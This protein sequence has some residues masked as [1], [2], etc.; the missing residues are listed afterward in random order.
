MVVHTF[1]SRRQSHA[2]LWLQEQVPG[3]PSSGSEGVGKQSA[4]DNKIKQG[5]GV[6][7]AGHV[8]VPASSRTWQL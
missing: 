8:P 7:E 3:Q 5:H 1:N 4:G 2:D 6:G